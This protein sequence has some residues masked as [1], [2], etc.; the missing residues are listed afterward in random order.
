MGLSARH[1]Q[2]QLRSRNSWRIKQQKR[3]VS[4]QRANECNFKRQNAMKSSCSCVTCWKP[5][6]T[7]CKDDDDKQT[8][9][10]NTATRSS[11]SD[12][13]TSEDGADRN[14]IQAEAS[15]TFGASAVQSTG[16]CAKIWK[17]SARFD[18][19]TEVKA[20]TE[21]GKQERTFA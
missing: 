20:K 19:T 2:Y 1:P 17:N 6:E 3:A 16:Q 14:S 21:E 7:E 10:Q 4:C 15:R 8:K 11:V 12:K 18:N 9:N 5:K 13:R